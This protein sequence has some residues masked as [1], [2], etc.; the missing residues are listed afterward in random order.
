[1]TE[2]S[3]RITLANIVKINDPPIKLLHSDYYESEGKYSHPSRTRIIAEMR[4][5]LSL[6]LKVPKQ[7]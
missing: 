5:R 7:T 2:A 6:N 4:E 3:K 1:M